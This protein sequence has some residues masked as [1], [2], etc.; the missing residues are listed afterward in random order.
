[1]EFDTPR[2]NRLR[3]GPLLNVFRTAPGAFCIPL[4]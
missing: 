2:H 4:L 1:M 3:T